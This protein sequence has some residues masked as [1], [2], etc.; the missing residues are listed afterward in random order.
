M[1]MAASISPMS[2]THSK[3]WSTPFGSSSRTASSR[4]AAA[5]PLRKSVA[6]NRRASASFSGLLST[7][8]MRDARAKRQPWITFRPIPPTPMTTAVSLVATWARLIAAPTPVMTAQPM[9][10]ADGR[11]TSAGMGTTW[12]ASTTV[13]SQNTEA[14]AKL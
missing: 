12:I 8:T 2:P 4:F 14:L 7:A 6:P 11:G 1:A 13:C 10:D 3:A 5:T 9:S